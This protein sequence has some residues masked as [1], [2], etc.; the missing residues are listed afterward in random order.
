MQNI[1]SNFDNGKVLQLKVSPR[2]KENFNDEQNVYKKP[3][4]KT[5]RAYL[6]SFN[7]PWIKKKKKCQHEKENKSTRRPVWKLKKKKKTASFARLKHSLI[8]TRVIYSAK[9]K[10][11][12]V[13][14]PLRDKLM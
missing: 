8:Q 2:K 5:E 9:E 6:H 11:F 14:Y 7:K 13:G 12:Q 10:R 1:S 4:K 3:E